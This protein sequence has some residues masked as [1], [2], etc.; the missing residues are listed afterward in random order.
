M[1]THLNVCEYHIESLPAF[2]DS[3]SPEK[4]VLSTVT[5]QNYYPGSIPL[6]YHMPSP[7]FIPNFRPSP[8]LSTNHSSSRELIPAKTTKTSV[9][10]VRI[11]FPQLSTVSTRKTLSCNRTQ[12][13]SSSSS[14]TQSDKE[15]ILLDTIDKRMFTI[16]YIVRN[17]Q[18]INSLFS[19][20]NLM[21]IA[22]D[23]ESLTSFLGH[24]SPYS[25]RG[26]V[27]ALKK[28]I[29]ENLKKKL[30]K[31]R[32]YSII[33]DDSKDKGGKIEFCV[34]IR[35]YG[36]NKEIVSTFLEFCQLGEGGSRAD[37]LFGLLEKVLEDWELNPRDMIALTSDGASNMSG[38]LS[39]VFARLK[40]KYK[41]K[42]LIFVHCAA[43]RCNLLAE[44]LLTR[45][46]VSPTF[47]ETLSII[48]NIASLFHYSPTQ[49]H[50]LD[51]IVKRLGYSVLAIPREGD[52]RWM[53]R[54]G[55]FDF[56]SS[57]F[58]SLF[59]FFSVDAVLKI[60]PALFIFFKKIPH[61]L[62]KDPSD[63]AKKRDVNKIFFPFFIDNIS[64]LHV[65]LGFVNN[66]CKIFQKNSFHYLSISYIVELLLIGLRNSYSR[67]SPFQTLSAL[68]KSS[69]S[70]YPTSFATELPR[71]RKRESDGSF[72]LYKS[73]SSLHREKRKKARCSDQLKQNGS[74]DKT[75]E[76][77]MFC[78]S[79]V[80]NI[81]I[82]YKCS[83]VFYSF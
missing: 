44:S 73:S 12:P 18:S 17:K 48:S 64:V 23:E 66:V 47:S 45:Y 62:P 32:Y 59:C 40:K 81:K 26:F 54:F 80:M 53:A 22:G 31:Y 69:T 51:K 6:L 16:H 65:L 29:K 39:G 55:G 19:L 14:A 25:M 13:S 63:I 46:D 35:I 49:K 2:L 76:V 15:S 27:M 61:P 21:N 28:A 67:S 77:L 50:I 56:F 30:K 71:K 34:Y 78:L 75:A 82:I 4:A 36:R 83:F 79:E 38:Y 3:Y 72:V 9:Q 52:T 42:R 37:V 20:Q 74:I 41:M 24:T 8:V 33:V 5:Y 60:L 11:S 7:F 57:R 70:A 43:H 68:A 10:N 58:Y 1:T